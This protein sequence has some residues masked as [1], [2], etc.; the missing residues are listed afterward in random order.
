MLYPNLAKR[1]TKYLCSNI[2]V[3]DFRVKKERNKIFEND[4]KI[5]IQW[6][7][8]AIGYDQRIFW[9][10]KKESTTMPKVSWNE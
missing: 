10:E 6:K 3:N 5:N 7:V 2:H 9:E 1:M 4:K 8:T